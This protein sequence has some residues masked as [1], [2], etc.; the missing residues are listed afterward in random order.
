MIAR[1]ARPLALCLLT[2]ALVGCDFEL[3]LL[4]PGTSSSGGYD[5]GGGASGYPGAP[6]DPDLVVT[7]SIFVDG[8]PVAP[9]EA[10]IEVYAPQ[11]TLEPLTLEFVV[12]EDHGWFDGSGPR[13]PVTS[14]GYEL[15]F[16]SLA[17][18]VACT[19]VARVIL[20]NG[21]RSELQSL[22]D[23]SYGCYAQWG[24]LPGSTFEMPGYGVDDEHW[25]EGT[26]FVDGMLAEQGTAGVE[27]EVRRRGQEP[28][29]FVTTGADGSFRVSL[30]GPQW[31][32]LCTSGIA[33]RFRAGDYEEF[34]D[35]TG[36]GGPE[37]CGPGRRMPPVRLGQALA[38]EGVV[39]AG[40]APVGEGEGWVRLLDPAD[41]TLVGDTVWT[42]DNGAYRL[43]F[44]QGLDDPG[45]EWL[46]EGGITDGASEVRPYQRFDYCAE[47]EWHE[48]DLPVG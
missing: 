30:D 17:D 22:S 32:V 27:V 37:S 8:Y 28:P 23:A 39:R 20:W 25:V 7:G 19:Y 46:I 2:V 40:D 35:V 11:D 34:V 16:G 42:Q 3:D 44:P 33:A 43:Y 26:V 31:F 41:S 48:F 38:A 4:G 15:N 12:Q 21:T 47:T 5:Y 18:S 9:Q 45:C 29:A 10:F 1:A 13:A 24:H 36:L 6:T 14:G